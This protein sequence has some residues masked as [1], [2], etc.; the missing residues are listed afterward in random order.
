MA[1]RFDRLITVTLTLAVVIMAAAISKRVFLSRPKLGPPPEVTFEPG[2]KSLQ[3][4]GRA[5]GDTAAPVQ[6]VETVDLQCP[7]CASYQSVLDDVV[8]EYNGKVAVTFVHFPVVTHEQARAAHRGAE[9]ALRVNRFRE[10]VATVYKDQQSLPKRPLWEFAKAV[11][12]QD[13]A[14]FASCMSDSLGIDGAI[15]AGMKMGESLKVIRT[16]TIIVNGWR[17][18]SLPHPTHLTNLIDD[19]LDGK[20]PISDSG[21]AR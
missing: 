11:G 5:M 14:G 7:G 13:S 18:S 2:W 6:I 10:F 3:A 20:S 21:A 9:C 12:L 15:T 19:L 8:K 16:P 17:Y 1:D 4:V